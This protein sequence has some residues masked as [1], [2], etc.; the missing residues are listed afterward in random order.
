MMSVRNRGC[1]PELDKE[2]VFLKPLDVPSDE[3]WQ[4]KEP[5]KPY[6]RMH[7]HHTLASARRYAFF[8]PFRDLIP[9]D[10]LDFILNS[11]YDHSQEI[12]P[13]P[14]DIYLQPETLGQVTWRRLRNTSDLKSSLEARARIE[15]QQQK[16]FLAGHGH[17]PFKLNKYHPVIISGIEE[18]RHPSNVK[19]MNSSHHSPQTNAGYSR[20]DSDGNFYQY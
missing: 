19:L 14:I 10:D 13:D 20:Q 1:V 16:L 8:R 11:P 9:G 4:Q 3:V 15:L 6:E 12:F 2:G 7:A 18:R 5:L 17:L